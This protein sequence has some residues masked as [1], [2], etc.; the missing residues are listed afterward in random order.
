MKYLQ[1]KSYTAVFIALAVL[2]VLPFFV[3]ADGHTPPQ[4]NPLI[5]CEGPD[6]TFNDV[7]KT[8]D[9]VID[10]L[11]KIAIPIA[12]IL[13]AYAGFLYLTAG[14]KTGQIQKAHGIFTDVFI[15]FVITISA[16]LIVNTIVSPLI[17]D[18]YNALLEQQA[19]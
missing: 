16:W 9:N 1:V 12:M 14:G 18:D 10:F 3:Y 15:G 7:I 13:F 5:V 19:E 2:A 6:C 4:D 17:S 8:I 11:V